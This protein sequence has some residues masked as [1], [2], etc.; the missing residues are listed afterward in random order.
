LGDEDK[1]QFALAQYDSL[2]EMSQLH[3]VCVS[4]LACWHLRRKGAWAE[5]VARGE[6]ALAQP[7]QFAYYRA[8]LALEVDIAQGMRLLAGKVAFFV[9]QP[10][11]LWLI[12]WRSRLELVRLRA[13]LALVCWRQNDPCWQRHWTAVQ[14]RTDPYFL[15][16]RDPELAAHFWRL[17]LLIGE[18]FDEAAN[19]FRQNGRTDLLLPLLTHELPSV[20]ARTATLLAHVGDEGGMTG[21]TAVLATEKDAAARQAIEQALRRLENQ[22]PPLLTIQLMGPFRLKR[23]DA[24]V[25]DAAWYRPIVQRLFQYFSLHAGK[26]LSK[27]QILEALWPDSDPEKA[28]GTFRT[29][30][31]RLRKVLEPALRT[32]SANRYIE[33]RGETLRLNSA[34]VQLDVA[35]FEEAVTAVLQTHQP[36]AIPQL[37]EPL[38][39]ALTNYAPLLP[40]LP[41]ADWLLEPRQKLEELYIEGSL[42]VAQAYL[43]RADPAQTMVWARQ[44]IETAP[45]LEEA[46]R[47]LMCSYA[48][49]GQRS[50]AL[51]VF[52]EAVTKLQQELNLPPSE[53]TIWLAERL[54][55]GEPI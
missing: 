47:L 17:A 9:P 52:A 39:H 49:Q 54:R 51:R 12:S 46:Y 55:R 11:T 14:N 16:Y 2:A 30:Y 10:D 18:K 37:S 3:Q 33:V 8:R 40:S 32:K 44:I 23:G 27:D 31:S 42:Y 25:A 34:L 1:V 36:D 28:W 7:S 4:W 38:L 19:V 5:A 53:K 6:S 29:V 13:L 45:W 20:R 15:P 35:E 50:Q 26:F 48:R 24:R 41:Y 43:A 21:L 22:P